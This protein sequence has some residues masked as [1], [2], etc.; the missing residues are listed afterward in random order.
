M[1]A[2]SKPG[3]KTFLHDPLYSFPLSASWK[4]MPRVALEATW[5][6]AELLLACV[7]KG[8]AQSTPPPPLPLTELYV[9]K[10]LTSIMLS[11]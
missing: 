4:S 1:C 8:Q 5:E 10:K 7:N 11:H 3:H 2:I 9:S 6:V